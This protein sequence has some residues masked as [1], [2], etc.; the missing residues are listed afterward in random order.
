MKPTLIMV[1]T[2]TTTT[3]NLLDLRQVMKYRCFMRGTVMRR[4]V[5][6]GSVGL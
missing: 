1:S 3:A 6:N 5:Q 4:I 2:G